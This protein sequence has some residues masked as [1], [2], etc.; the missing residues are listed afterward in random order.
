MDIFL[1]WGWSFM[2][3]FTS[4]GSFLQTEVIAFGYHTTVGGMIFGV[5]ITG[6]LLYRLVKFLLGWIDILT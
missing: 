4:I 5:A 3:T 2:Q 1:D 6:L